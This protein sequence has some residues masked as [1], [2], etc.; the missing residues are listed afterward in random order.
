MKRRSSAEK[1]GEEWLLRMCLQFEE[2]GPG[3]VDYV[4]SYKNSPPGERGQS[5]KNLLAMSIFEAKYQGL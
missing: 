5:K 4:I 2:W 1:G 3:I